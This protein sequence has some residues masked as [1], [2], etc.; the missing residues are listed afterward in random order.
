MSLSGTAGARPPRVSLTNL[1]TNETAEMPFTPNEFVESVAVNWARQ[2]ILGMSHE[3]LQYTNTGNYTLNDLDFAFRATTPA[4]A[5]AIHD[6]RRF[7]LS[8]CYAPEGAEGLRDGAPPRILF[9]WPQV[10]SMTCIL[11]RDLRITHSAFNSEGLTTRFNARFSLEEA[12]NVRLTMDEV[13]QYGTQ[14]SSAAAE[15]SDATP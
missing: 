1:R 13:R 3:Q 11:S 12:R 10:V 5:K 15:E 2:A 14:R 9:F 8:L 6:G 7:L 4:E